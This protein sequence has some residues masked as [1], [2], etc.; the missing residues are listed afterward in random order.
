MR[1]DLTGCPRRTRNRVCDITSMLQSGELTRDKVAA[2]LPALAIGK[3]ARKR[4]PWSRKLRPALSVLAAWLGF[5]VAF[6]AFPL[7][8]FLLPRWQLRRRPMV[9]CLP[10]WAT[11]WAAHKITNSPFNCILA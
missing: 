9:Q 6:V 3:L 11:R 1:H 2:S 10:W 8:G 7:G 5:I 4:C